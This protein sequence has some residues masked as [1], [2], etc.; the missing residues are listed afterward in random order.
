MF[1]C[2]LLLHA[3]IISAFTSLRIYSCN[4][5]IS[6]SNDK[7]DVN[8]AVVLILLQMHKYSNSEINDER[9]DHNQEV[10]L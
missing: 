1:I 8:I 2:L 7:I 6:C 4:Q 5:G 9:F 3:S 10:N